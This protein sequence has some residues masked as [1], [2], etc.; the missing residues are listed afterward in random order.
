VISSDEFWLLAMSVERSW[1]D[2]NGG[3]SV[4]AIRHLGQYFL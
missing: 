4:V 1:A 2:I 3:L